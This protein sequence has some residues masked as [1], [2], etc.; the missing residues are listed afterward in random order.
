MALGPMPPRDT[1]A[2]AFLHDMH[3]RITTAESEGK[4][5]EAV[6]LREMLRVGRMIM[7]GGQVAAPPG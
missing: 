4:Y 5:A 2:G 3:E 6:E 1:V 7:A